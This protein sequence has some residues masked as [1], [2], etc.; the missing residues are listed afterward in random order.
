MFAS[1]EKYMSKVG[2]TQLDRK[3]YPLP[4]PNRIHIYCNYEILGKFYIKATIITIKL[5]NHE[6]NN[7]KHRLMVSMY[8]PQHRKR[9][10]SAL[11]A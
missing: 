11:D 8:L 1:V 7:C 10:E 4:H 9:L 3:L 5:H 6:G 2:F